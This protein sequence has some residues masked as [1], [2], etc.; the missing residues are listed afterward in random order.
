M[1]IGEG[2]QLLTALTAFIS[3]MLSLRNGRKLTEVH[4]ST[5]GLAARNEVIAEELGRE[6]GKAEEKAN[7]NGGPNNGE[8]RP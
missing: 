5:N 6:K 8:H 4:K 3:C 2:A 7:Q 1:T